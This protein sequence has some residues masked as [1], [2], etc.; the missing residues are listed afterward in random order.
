MVNVM[1]QS[2]STACT[3]LHWLWVTSG[4]DVAVVQ[5]EIHAAGHR[6]IW[7]HCSVHAEDARW[8]SRHTR[9]ADCY[10]SPSVTSPASGLKR[11]KRCHRRIVSSAGCVATGSNTNWRTW[12]R[13][14]PGSWSWQGRHQDSWQTTWNVVGSRR[15]LSDVEILDSCWRVPNRM[16]SD[17]SAFSLC[18]KE[19]LLASISAMHG[20]MS[21]VAQRCAG[22]TYVEP[23]VCESS[24]KLC[25][26]MPRLWTMSCNCAASVRVTRSDH[27]FICRY[28]CCARPIR[29]HVS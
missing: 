15:C 14:I 5:S 24:A 4:V 3:A 10:T 8:L 6:P 26:W 18:R 21:R 13:G 27:S 2:V 19:L 29:C 16:N 22:R 17:L 25:N 9:L 7:P 20:T 12:Q 28:D 23:A 11:A 1:H